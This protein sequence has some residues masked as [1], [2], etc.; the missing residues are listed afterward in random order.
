V[1]KLKLKVVEE[2]SFAREAETKKESER[3]EANE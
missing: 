3:R 1:D 2:C